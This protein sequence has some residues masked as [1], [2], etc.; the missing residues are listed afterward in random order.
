MNPI[1]LFELLGQPDFQRG[2]IV[3]GMGLV[4]VLVARK[5]GWLMIWGIGA[6]AALSWVGLL[7]TSPQTPGWAL[8]VTVVIALAGTWAF[9]VLLSRA[10]S[11]AVGLS[12]GLWVLG[13]WGTV[14][15]TERAAVPMGV[16]AA[17]LPALW[18]GLKVRVGWHGAA[19]AIAA[20]GFVIVTDGAARTSAMIGSFGMVGMAMVAA[21]SAR[22]VRKGQFLSSWWLV[23]SQA[24]HV[25]ISGRVAGQTWDSGGA[26][27]IVILSSIL[28]GAGL[29]WGVR[30]T[31]AP[32]SNS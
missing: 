24:L 13:V 10:R 30:G 31:H 1:T 5:L 6:F 3:G 7:R 4:A 18:P 22:T 15:D 19:I 26:L 17:M 27:T 29:A 12:F 23:A 21:L 8:P 14:P 9:R 2:L 11:W 20:L 28:T 25:I 32:V 16:L